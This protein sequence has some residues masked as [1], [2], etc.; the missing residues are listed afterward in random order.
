MEKEILVK[1]DCGMHYGKNP[2]PCS[3]CNYFNKQKPYTT[4]NAHALAM[5]NNGT[6]I[7]GD[8]ICQ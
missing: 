1:K 3:K 8:T 2:G 7:K 6:I 5:I 4:A